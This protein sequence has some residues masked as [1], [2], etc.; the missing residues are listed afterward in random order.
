MSNVIKKVIKNWVEYD[1]YANG[2]AAGAGDVSWPASATNWHL[3]V[4]DWTTGKLIKDWWAVPT[5]P[6]VN[7][8]TITFTQNWTSVWDIT[9]NQSSDETIAFTDTTYESKAASSWW[10][11]VSLVTTWEKYTWNNKQSALSTQTAY[12][13]KWTA[14]KVP[15]ITTN[16]LWQVTAISETNITFP[17]TSVGGS[18]WAVGLKTVNWNSLVGSWDIT[19]SWWITNNT[20][21]TS[22]TVT[23]IWAGTEA[24]YT[25]LSSKSANTIYFTF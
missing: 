3:A 4:F 24:Q 7:N 5:I 20:T 17:V 25:A 6:T 10:T 2:G 23:Q 8:K 21:W 11:A 16:T 19:I 15:T 9:L 14:T 22:T 12:T 18:T 13:T 1:I